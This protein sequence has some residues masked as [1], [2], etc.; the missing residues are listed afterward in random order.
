[1]RISRNLQFVFSVG[2]A[3]SIIFFILAADVSTFGELLGHHARA[4]AADSSDNPNSPSHTAEP[5][6]NACY[7]Y[8]TPS[9][10]RIFLKFRNFS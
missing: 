3:K 8:F 7:R 9:L 2:S 1:M 10:F 5:S 4:A 6:I